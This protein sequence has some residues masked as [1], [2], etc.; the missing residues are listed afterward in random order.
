[1]RRAVLLGHSMGTQVALEGYRRLPDRVAGL[2]PGRRAVRLLFHTMYGSDLGDRL[3]PLVRHGVPLVLPALLR[4]WGP[5]WRGPLPYP[6]AALLG[7]MGERAD[8][9]DMDGYFQ[10]MARLDPLVLV[11]VA[12]GMH[13]HSAADVPVDVRVP[14]LVVAGGRDPWTP[15]AL[16]RQM[17]EAL[18]DAELHVARRGQP[19]AA[20]RGARRPGGA[21]PGLAGRAVPA[22]GRAGPGRTVGR[23]WIG[24]ADARPDPAPA[25]RPAPGWACWPAAWPWSWPGWRCSPSCWRRR[26]GWSGGTTVRPWTTRAASTTAPGTSAGAEPVAYRL[27]RP[28]VRGQDGAAGGGR[29]PGRPGQGLMGR[30]QVPEGTGMV[31]LYPSDVAEAYWMKNTL[32]P[33]SIAFVAADGRVVSVAEMT[34]CEADP[35]PSYP[36]AGPY[37]YAVE[38]AAGSFGEAGIGP[39]AKVVPVDLGSTP[40]TGVTTQVSDKI[41]PSDPLA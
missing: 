14:A 38:L 16:A 17:A 15:P 24:W 20:H 2:D 34:P 41:K 22:P 30:R 27:E 37:R 11:K 31:F 36:P 8:P 4:L 29:R 7:S 23:H 1:M 9:E 32:V 35:C 39:G 25:P 13:R 3:F 33:L 28:A 21:G 19:L 12:E 5:L 6:V 40:R 26:P 10:H 18:P